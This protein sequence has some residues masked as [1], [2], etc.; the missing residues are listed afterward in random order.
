MKLAIVAQ[1]IVDALP[2]G[3]LTVQELYASLDF[4][5]PSNSHLAIPD[6][7]TGEFST[8]V[9]MRRHKFLT[10][11]EEL[12]GN[13]L[14]FHYCRHDGDMLLEEVATL[15][16][17]A[18]LVLG[19]AGVFNVFTDVEL[20]FEGF[21]LRPYRVTYSDQKGERVIFDR[22]HLTDERHF[23]NRRIEWLEAAA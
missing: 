21:K 8:A 1:Q 7:H 4:R 18:K 5:G 22:E 20:V 10:G 11:D 16:E 19:G 2:D 15:E 6:W 3:M 9:E 12:N 23:L 14:V 17:A 13:F